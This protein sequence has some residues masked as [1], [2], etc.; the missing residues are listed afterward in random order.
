VIFDTKIKGVCLPHSTY[1]SDVSKPA[2]KYWA[3]EVHKKGVD[4][5]N[6]PAI[7]TIGGLKV[8]FLSLVL[9]FAFLNFS[10]ESQLTD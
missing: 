10:I 9:H 8:D 1:A 4:G 7:I 5:W 3:Y 2:H 6:I